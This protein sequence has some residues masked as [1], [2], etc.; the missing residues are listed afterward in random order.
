MC[1]ELDVPND[2]WEGDEQKRG[3]LAIIAII[4]TRSKELVSLLEARAL[5]MIMGPPGQERAIEREREKASA[6]T[7][8]P[9]KNGKIKSAKKGMVEG[10][11]RE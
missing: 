1:E 10:V 8:L 7:R 3:T 4:T 6:T 11:R 5:G 2:V 9:L